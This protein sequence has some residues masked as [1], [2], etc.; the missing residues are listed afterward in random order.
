MD[1]FFIGLMNYWHR[2]L[3]RRAIKSEHYVNHCECGGIAQMEY[4]K[5]FNEIDMEPN[6][7]ELYVA[8]CSNPECHNVFVAMNTIVPV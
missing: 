8:F 1:K 3:I 7:R 6:R 4:F 5:G 2:R